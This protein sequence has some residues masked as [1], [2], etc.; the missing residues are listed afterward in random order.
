MYV[1]HSKNVWKVGAKY[2]ISV[3]LHGDNDGSLSFILAPSSIMFVH[4]FNFYELK[5]IFLLKL[6][7]GK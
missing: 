4:L 5:R 7:A 3:S 2:D 6:C 1:K